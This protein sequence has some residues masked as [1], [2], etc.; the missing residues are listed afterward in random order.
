MTIVRL[1]TAAQRSQA[2][3]GNP[4]IKIRAV[5]T[6]LVKYADGNM[7]AQQGQ[8]EAITWLT[9]FQAHTA[10]AHAAAAHADDAHADDAHADDDEDDDQWEPER[11]G[12][13]QVPPR[14]S[15]GHAPGPQ[16]R[17]KQTPALSGL[18]GG[19]PAQ[20]RKPNRKPSRRKRVQ[21][22]P[23]E[24]PQKHVR[25]ADEDSGSDAP[26]ESESVDIELVDEDAPP[27]QSPEVRPP[28]EDGALNHTQ[29]S[30]AQGRMQTVRDLAAQYERD[31]D[32]R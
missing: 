7:S 22:P 17:E 25:F 32:F 12:A 29:R 4:Q 5:P 27:A 14:G 31:A 21:S 20:K 2:T 23:R 26:S 28:L 6:L 15:S 11:R 8:R 19:K 30:V 16:A 13:V 18:Y 1:D 9:Q 10:A 24:K 3:S